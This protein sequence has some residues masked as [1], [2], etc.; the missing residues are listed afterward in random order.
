MLQ[1]TQPLLDPRGDG[2][3]LGLV[4][5]FGEHPHDGFAG[6]DATGDFSA[7]GR[8]GQRGK[9][10]GCERPGP[11][12][13][14]LRLL[15]MGEEQAGFA[16]GAGL[17]LQV[18]RHRSA[19]VAE[20]V[21]EFSVLQRG[22]GEFEAIGVCLPVVQT[23]AEDGDGAA[24][25]T[26]RPATEPGEHRG[27]RRERCKCK[28]SSLHFAF[29]KHLTTPS[30]H[31]TYRRPCA[32]AMPSQTGGLARSMPVLWLPLSTATAQSLAPRLPSRASSC[33]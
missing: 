13:G 2:V 11:D 14:R 26:E 17:G 3:V 28:P 5:R 27:E 9:A 23:V 29:P 8:V 10:R 19:E 1:V 15:G 25:G 6:E 30:R 22:G 4:A 21:G 33:S 16:G 7:R 24:L 12:D 18:H 31:D 20:E 32:T